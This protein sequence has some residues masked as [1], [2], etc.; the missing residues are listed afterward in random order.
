MV[1]YEDASEHIKRKDNLGLIWDIYRIDSPNMRE[2]YAAT[3]DVGGRYETCVET[4]E[5]VDADSGGENFRLLRL[6]KLLDIR[7]DGRMENRGVG[8]LLLR[9]AV[10]ECKRLGHL[11]L[12]GDLS[13]EDKD[14]FDKLKH[15]YE[16]EGF[17]VEFFCSDDPRYSPI[18]LGRAEIIF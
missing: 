5:I 4:H 14:H 15:F 2:W 7:I 6:A 1:N 10:G 9:E 16:K 8:S 12:E 17:T 13:R 3:G 18:M 11:G